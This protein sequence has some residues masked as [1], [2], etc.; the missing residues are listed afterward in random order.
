MSARQGI[1]HKLIVS[2]RLK[3]ARYNMLP[4]VQF[5]LTVDALAVSKQHCHDE[6][7]LR[8]YNKTVTIK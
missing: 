7:Q 5:D 1:L 4:R 2:S 3:I 8:S 6:Q